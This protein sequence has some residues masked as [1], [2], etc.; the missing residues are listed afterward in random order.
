[1]Q[2][3]W[4]Y[5]STQMGDTKKTWWTRPLSTML[6]KLI[7][8]NYMPNLKSHYIIGVEVTGIL[9]Q[10]QIEHEYL[11]SL[12]FFIKNYIIFYI[13]SIFEYKNFYYWFYFQQSLH[14]V[15]G[16]SGTKKFLISHPHCLVYYYY[17][18]IFVIFS[19]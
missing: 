3:F 4:L 12:K 9:M 6:W 10:A 14:K 13:G 2:F 19:A 17:Y 8:Q 1:M 16:I 15:S 5:R 11:I 7:S 18:C